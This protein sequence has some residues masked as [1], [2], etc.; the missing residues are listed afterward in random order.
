MPLANKFLSAE[1]K[2]RLAYSPCKQ[3]SDTSRWRNSRAS[4]LYVSVAAGANSSAV[5][6][7]ARRES[8]LTPLDIVEAKFILPSRFGL[9]EA[10]NVS[11]ESVGPRIEYLG[12]AIPRPSPNFLTSFQANFFR[13]R[14]S[15][16]CATIA[17]VLLPCSSRIALFYSFTPLLVTR[18]KTRPKEHLHRLHL[19]RISKLAT[20][21]I[22]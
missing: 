2:K 14:D 17:S 19:P 13:S 16:F 10:T 7:R 21:K 3:E 8:D 4:G 9:G 22:C 5:E 15:S 11:P 6:K 18:K 1:R 12:A 20:K